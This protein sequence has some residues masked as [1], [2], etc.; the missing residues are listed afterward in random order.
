M[1]EC[2][3]CGALF[4]PES[5][6]KIDTANAAYCSQEKKIKQTPLIGLWRDDQRQSIKN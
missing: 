5:R 2:V 6:V 3:N 4:D 1:E